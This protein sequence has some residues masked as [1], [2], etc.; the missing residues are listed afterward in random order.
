MSNYIVDGSSEVRSSSKSIFLKMGEVNSKNDL[1]AI[2]K[3]NC[4][5]DS[6][7]KWKNIIDK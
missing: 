7:E 1:E 5:R 6:W 2:F 4:G 3:K